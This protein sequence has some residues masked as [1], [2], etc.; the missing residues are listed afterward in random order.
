MGSADEADA[1]ARVTL[2]ARSTTYVTDVTDEYNL[3]AERIDFTG[4]LQVAA[5]ASGS[6]SATASASAEFYAREII[7][8]AGEQG[9]DVSANADGGTGIDEGQEVVRSADEAD[10]EAQVLFGAYGYIDSFDAGYT[11]WDAA[12]TIDF[13]GGLQVV[14]DATGSA[15]GDAVAL[16]TFDAQERIS[17]ITGAEDAV[18]ISANTDGG[19][20]GSS[21]ADLSINADNEGGGDVAISGRLSVVADA[22]DDSGS[23]TGDAYA[24]LTVT[25]PLGVELGS[26][27]VSAAAD[28]GDAEAVLDLSA[29]G[30]VVVTTGEGA[31]TVDAASQRK[32]EARGELSGQGV[33]LNGDLSLRAD[34][35][36]EGEYKNGG[37][38]LQEA[39]YADII[40]SST[41][42]IDADTASLGS[43]GG[44]IV[45]D[46]DAA[47]AA[48]SAYAVA[49]YR[50]AERSN[51]AF[52]GEHLITA[53]AT[54][55]RVVNSD[56]GFSLVGGEDVTSAPGSAFTIAATA[57][58][59]DA[60][61]GNAEA[62]AD[63]MA[64]AEADHID[65]DAT[66]DIDAL[67]GADSVSGYADAQAGALARL[68]A[69]QLRVAGG[70]D[71][72]AVAV[73]SGAEGRDAGLELD[74]L[75]EL[76]ISGE[77][78]LADGV[79]SAWAIIGLAAESMDVATVGGVAVFGDQVVLNGD[80]AS[81]AGARSSEDGGA[82]FGLA[83]DLLVGRS[84]L[85]Y[86]GEIDT[87]AQ[88][89]GS[90]NGLEVGA[91]MTALIS[92]DVLNVT[93]TPTLP[94]ATA[95]AGADAA[96]Q[97]EES[98]YQVC[99]E[100][101]CDPVELGVWLDFEGMIGLDESVAYAQLVLLGETINIEVVQAA[102]DIVNNLNR[103]PE[104]GAG[105]AGFDGDG[106]SR[107][108]A[109]GNLI[110]GLGFALQ[111]P[112]PDVQGG[113][114][115]IAAGADPGAVLPAPAGG[116]FGSS[117]KTPCDRQQ[118]VN[119]GCI[120]PDDENENEQ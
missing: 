54:G 5:N 46:A 120:G 101:S 106:A 89:S 33:T 112:Q 99:I 90:G 34:A 12:D 73:S 49:G 97:G 1:E 18:S 6:S 11:E 25:A 9:F 7:V 81:L 48:G 100:G 83:V 114:E 40:A 45:M 22:A 24:D 105:V 113:V 60:D 77:I 82:V 78:A 68:S 74:L 15:S 104:S 13:T 103:G 47:N 26:A 38:G 96:V 55:T 110:P 108:D 36:G 31:I 87:S 92:E 91:A 116:L 35:D 95:T 32:A 37:T 65:F 67:A 63:A 56:A 109:Q 115:Q 44:T 53:D 29:E 16:A 30:G 102:D 119:A 61:G 59:V 28:V 39:L 23:G 66:L 17:I 42:E 19:G 52:A 86:T 58:A 64:I 3:T 93:A 50:H 71:V 27:T 88:V 10:A 76:P 107:F 69:S 57:N 4:E 118:L 51:T 117:P 20:A 72:N 21:D 62:L 98:Q 94:A 79:P 75:G 2:G 43:V 14:A 84:S 8:N 80:I 111:P 41:L 70:M 85:D